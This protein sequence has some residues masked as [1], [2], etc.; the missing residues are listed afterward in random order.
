M[1]M[2]G[3]DQKSLRGFREF[4]KMRHELNKNEQKKQFSDDDTGSEKTLNKRRDS[5]IRGN[6]NTNH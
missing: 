4:K 5:N 6:M 2:K 1:K 3:R